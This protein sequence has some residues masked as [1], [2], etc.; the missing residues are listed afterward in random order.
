MLHTVCCIKGVGLRGSM[1]V[2]Y[3][4]KRCL[5]PATSWENIF[6]YPISLLLMPSQVAT[7]AHNRGASVGNQSA[8]EMTM[9]N[10]FNPRATGSVH[11]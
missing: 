2:P 9:A 5:N 11:K 3:A 1:L 4:N 10:F 8:K 7:C 6:T